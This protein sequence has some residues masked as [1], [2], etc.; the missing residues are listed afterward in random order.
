MLVFAPHLGFFEKASGLSDPRKQ[1]VLFPFYN[2][3]NG[4]P[5]K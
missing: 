3:G 2:Q 4:G 1:A 5:R